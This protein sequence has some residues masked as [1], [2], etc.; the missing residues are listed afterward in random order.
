MIA[1][2]HLIVRR[3]EI[4]RQV[5]ISS[6]EAACLCGTYWMT[7][8]QHAE[9]PVWGMWRNCSSGINFF[10]LFYFA[11]ANRWLIGKSI[12][13]EGLAKSRRTDA[14]SPVGLTWDNQ[15]RCRSPCSDAVESEMRS[16]SAHWVE[17]QKPTGYEARMAEVRRINSLSDEHSCAE[18]LALSAWTCHLGEDELK[19]AVRS[20]YKQL[21]LL[22]HPDKCAGRPEDVESARNAYHRLLL[23]FQAYQEQASSKTESM[24]V[25]T[26][27]LPNFVLDP[28]DKTYH[29]VYCHPEPDDTLGVS[30]LENGVE[31]ASCHLFMRPNSPPSYFYRSSCGQDFVGVHDGSCFVYT[32]FYQGTSI[33]ETSMHKK[34]HDKKPSQGGFFT[35]HYNCDGASAAEAMPL[36][37]AW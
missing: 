11:S 19:R 26:C 30:Y 28:R 25:V 16:T 1:D 29:M 2:P 18:V 34:W 4:P 24:M 8:E 33:D 6:K 14:A 5:V 10:V 35:K 31:Y 13:N 12:G 9:R 15:V 7:G 17:T 23:A 3:S 36:S 32:G 22:V 21:A 20:T 27:G 37:L